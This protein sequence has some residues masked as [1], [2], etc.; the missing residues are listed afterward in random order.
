[1]SHRHATY[2]CSAIARPARLLER[3][4][5]RKRKL[6]NFFESWSPA[7]A[8]VDSSFKTS[9]WWQI[10]GRIYSIRHNHAHRFRHRVPCCYL[11]CVEI[12]WLN[13]KS[14][15]CSIWTRRRIRISLSCLPFNKWFPYAFRTRVSFGY[16]Q[17]LEIPDNRRS[18][19]VLLNHPSFDFSRTLVL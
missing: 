18:T 8:N 7:R 2:K 13:T 14:K 19:R 4:L 17:Q 6:F 5:L 9:S 12:Q 3:M 11:L 15:W 1:M 10:R 16:L